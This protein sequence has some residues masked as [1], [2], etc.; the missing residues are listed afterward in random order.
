MNAD[1]LEQMGLQ[2]MI[3]LTL[4]NFTSTST[5]EAARSGDLSLVKAFTYNGLG[6]CDYDIATAEKNGHLDIINFHSTSD[7]NSLN[8]E[9]ISG[10]EPDKEKLH[11]LLIKEEIYE[12]TIQDTLIKVIDFLFTKK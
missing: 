3:T 5:F 6:F 7:L 4:S 11:N 8:N 12:D 1:E 9:C 10:N 2:E